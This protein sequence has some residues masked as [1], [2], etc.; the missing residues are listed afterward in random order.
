MSIQHNPKLEDLE[1][2]YDKPTF[3]RNRGRIIDYIVLGLDFIVYGEGKVTLYRNK[4]N[5]TI[6]DRKQ[7]LSQFNGTCPI[8]GLVGIPIYNKNYI[9]YNTKDNKLF[10]VDHI[11]PISMGGTKN[12]DNLQILCP[13][14]N[15][16]KKES[17]YAKG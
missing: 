2:L 5:I 12:L 16:S 6:S 8:C 4:E 11:I 3:Q 10:H 17:Y 1:K 7:A 15:Q 9:D 14:C 13:H